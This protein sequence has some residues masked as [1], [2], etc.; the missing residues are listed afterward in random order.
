MKKHFI[1][2][3]STIICFSC[4][5]DALSRLSMAEKLISSHPDSAL[6]ILRAI[7]RNSLKTPRVTAKYS[8]LMSAALD[9]NY[10]DISSD[11][12]ISST[13]NYYSKHGGH[14]EKMLFHYNPPN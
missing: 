1:I 6:C 12:L 5:R 10:I 14:K 9:K 4:E 11:S 7:D 13:V 2:L 3:L 8:L